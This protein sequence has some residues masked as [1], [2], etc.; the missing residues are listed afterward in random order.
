MK[1]VILSAGQG[2]RL[3]PLTEKRPKC[4]IE[5]AGTPVL[6]WQLRSISRCPE[7]DEVV[8]VTGYAT[9]QVEAIVADFNSEGVRVRSLH[10]PFFAASDNLGTCWI[11]RHEMQEPFVLI[12]GDTLFEAEILQRLLGSATQGP[13][14]LTVDRKAEYDED[15]M[16]I[17]LDGG[18]LRQVGKKLDMEKVNGE[19]IGMTRFTDKGA[20][21]F[22]A[23]LERSMRF[24]SG[25]KRWYL[26]AID[27]IAQKHPV[28]ACFIDGLSWCEIDTHADVESANDVVRAWS[29]PLWDTVDSEAARGG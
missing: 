1:V 6:E 28:R 17:I 10:N 12:N 18:R 4:A 19:S 27:V 20:N 21:V 5:I 25:L 13:I 9:D 16:K 14:T 7:V 3:L 29:R 11:A 26:S 22:R 15:D 2:S 8:V 24:G 23:E